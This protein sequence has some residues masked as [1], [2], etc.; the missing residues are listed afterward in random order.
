MGEK[1][2]VKRSL[3]L[4]LVVALILSSTLTVATALTIKAAA[5]EKINIWGGTIQ[6]TQFVLLTSEVNIQGK[7]KV[8]VSISIRNGDTSAH[9]AIVTVQ[10]LDS[11][12][13]V[14]LDSAQ[15]TGNVGS[16]VTWSSTF[17]FSRGG[18]VATFDSPFGTCLAL[19]P[20]S[21]QCLS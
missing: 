11:N 3:P 19:G 16:G 8:D 12:G 2:Y 14:I 21:G 4:W 13:D 18:L 15:N 7:N 9:V 5:I 6:D 10:L 17:S 20:F 1:K